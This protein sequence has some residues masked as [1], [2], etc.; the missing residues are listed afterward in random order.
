MSPAA[1]SNQ[2]SFWLFSSISKRQFS[3]YTPTEEDPRREYPWDSKV[4]NDDKVLEGDFIAVRRDDEVIGVARVLS[5]KRWAGKRDEFRCPVCRSTNIRER[6][7]LGTWVCNKKHVF[8]SPDAGEV[9]VTKYEAHYG[10]TF[11]ACDPRIPWREFLQHRPFFSYNPWHSILKFDPEKLESHFPALLSLRDGIGNPPQPLE[12]E[13]A[14]EPDRYS[15]NDE[16]ERER[17]QRQI[18]ARRGQRDFR[19]KLLERYDSKCLIS[20]C[21]LVDALEAAHIVP[22]R[23]Q[24]DNEPSNG[25]LLRTDLH[26]L[27]DLDLLGIEP[28]TLRVHVR[29]RAR[30]GGYNE[31]DGA[32]LNCGSKRPSPAAL[33]VRWAKYVAGE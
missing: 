11:R 7:T 30:L 1:P 8:A 14:E 18:R 20:G 16:D 28:S 27:F 4:Q 29:E 33:E 3:G 25:L 15:P 32:Q 10:P 22:Y 24:K 13:E 26:T 19:L 6:P 21:S 23:G 9:D 17:I 5:I 31:F 2:P 12:P